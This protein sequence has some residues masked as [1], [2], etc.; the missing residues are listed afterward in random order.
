MCNGRMH[1]SRMRTIQCSGCLLGRGCLPMAGVYP[2]VVCLHKGGVC[3]E[4][5]LPRGRCLPKGGG[6]TPHWTQRQTPT[7]L[8]TE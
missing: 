3:L 2:G 7:T 4:G 5:C 1:S 6:G 8:W